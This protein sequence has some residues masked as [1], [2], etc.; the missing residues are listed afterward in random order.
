MAYLGGMNSPLL[1]LAVLRLVK[2]PLLRSKLPATREGLRYLD[3]FSLAV[4]GMANFSQAF[5]NFVLLRPSDGWII[6]KG[7]DRITV[8]DAVFTVLDWSCALILGLQE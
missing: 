5:L 2:F 4:L 7:F 6:G 1:L 8:L 3:V